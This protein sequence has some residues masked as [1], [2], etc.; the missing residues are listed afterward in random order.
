M[1]IKEVFDEVV[2]GDGS[3]ASRKFLLTVG[4]LFLVTGMALLG[5]RYTGIAAILPTFIGG[6]L[7]ILSL[8]LTGSIASKYFVGKAAAGFSISSDSKIDDKP[9]EDKKEEKKENKKEDEGA[10]D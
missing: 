4:S 7:G 5:G 6:I 2:A 9:T 10:G 8:Y 3:F 1:N